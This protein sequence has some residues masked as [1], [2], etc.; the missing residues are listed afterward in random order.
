MLNSVE[1]EGAGGGNGLSSTSDTNGIVVQSETSPINKKLHGEGGD[2]IK[3]KNN[4]AKVVVPSLFNVFPTLRKR[5]GSKA[6]TR[7][8]RGG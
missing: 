7:G 3:K 8:T 4:E 5:G 2:V 6:A 1:E